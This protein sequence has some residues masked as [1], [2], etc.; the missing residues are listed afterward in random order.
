MSLSF[1]E[2]QSQTSSTAVYPG[3]SEP[4]GLLYAAIGAGNEAGEILGKVKKAIRDDGYGTSHTDDLTDDRKEQILD[5]VGDVL[6]YLAR[7]CEEADSSLGSCAEKNVSKL[8][9]R[10]ERGVLGGSG[11]NR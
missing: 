10:L 3:Q 5:E 9:S 11:D 7:V 4:L 2:Y 6:W 8:Q 1:D